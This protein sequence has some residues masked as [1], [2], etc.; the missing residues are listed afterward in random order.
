MLCGLHGTPLPEATSRVMDFSLKA[1]AVIFDLDGVLVDS[2]FSVE[3]AWREWAAAQDVDPELVLAT[4]PGK[5]T[6]DAVVLLAPH[7]DADLEAARIVSR[8][9]ELVRMEQ[10]IPGAHSLVA[11]LPEGRWGIA[12]SGT[13][14]IATG[15]LNHAGFLFPQAFIAAE[16]VVRGK[17]DPEVYL[18]AAAAL[19]VDPSACIVFEDAPSGVAAATAAGCLVVGVL[20]WAAPALLGV[21]HTIRDFRS[22]RASLED[23]LVRFDFVSEAVW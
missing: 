8:E 5:R 22:V 15:R 21:P 2:R 16:M 19:G 12:T 1:R 18:R 13:I 11:S 17:P 20:T 9:L 4:I 6:R 10:P 3:R 7:A 14:A 23:D